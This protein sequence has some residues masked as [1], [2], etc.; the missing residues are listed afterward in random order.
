[1]SLQEGQG[2][3][4]FKVDENLPAEASEVLCRAG[5]DAVTVL[6]QSMGGATDGRLADLCRAEGRV[7]VTLDLDFSNIQAYPPSEYAGIIVLRLPHQ[8]KAQVLKSVAMLIPY[9]SQEPLIGHLWIMDER[10]IRIRA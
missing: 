2:V 6:D 4:R 3:L 7:R 9:L 8:D 5:H 1:M 10:K